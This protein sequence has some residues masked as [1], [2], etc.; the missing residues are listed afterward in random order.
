MGACADKATSSGANGVP[1]FFIQQNATVDVSPRYWQSTNP[2]ELHRLVGPLG[3]LSW[4]GLS[5]C[6]Y[7]TTLSRRSYHLA[8]L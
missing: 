5:G 3:L 4:A 2:T 6:F 1:T 7:V 8:A